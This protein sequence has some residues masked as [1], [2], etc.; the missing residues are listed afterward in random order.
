M[1]QKSPTKS[2][3]QKFASDWGVTVLSKGKQIVVLTIL[4]R[5]QN[6]QTKRGIGPLSL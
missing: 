6:K 4:E 3:K 5:D 1:S 2:R